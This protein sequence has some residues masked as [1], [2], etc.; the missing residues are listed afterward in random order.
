MMRSAIDVTTI[1]PI[2][3][4]EAMRITEVEFGRMLRAARELEP[5]DWARPTDCTGWDVRALMLHMLGTAESNAS[6]RES[7]HQ[8]RL[9]KRRFKEVGGHHWVDGVNEIQ[10]R[11]RSTLTN[12]EIVDRYAAIIPKAVHT[13]HR[14]P[15]VVRALPLVDLPEP[16]GRQPLGYL[17]D[18]GYTR[19]VWMHRVDMAQATGRPLALTPDHDGRIVA[20]IVREWSVVHGHAFV[21]ELDGPAG[22]TFTSGSGGEELQIDTVEFL[23]ILSGRGSGTGLLSYDFPL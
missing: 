2:G 14:L 23:R 4:D 1:A 22:G 19:D 6:L 8:I 10:I 16:F 9:G 18:M 12:E 3:H 7:A 21:L 5:S 15:R 13:R 20:D 17:M 11:E